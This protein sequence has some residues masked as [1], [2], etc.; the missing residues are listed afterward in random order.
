MKKMGVSLII[1]AMIFV[2][3]GCNKEKIEMTDLNKAEIESF[4]INNKPISSPLELYSITELQSFFGNQWGIQLEDIN[5]RFAIEYLRKVQVDSNFD[6]YYVAYPVSEGGK[7]LLFLTYSIDFETDKIKLRSSDY[8]YVNDLSD[9]KEFDEVDG[10]CT[11][12]DIKSLAPCTLLVS[13]RSSSTDSYSL[14]MDGNV[15][16][17]TYGRTDGKVISHKVISVD[18]SISP[19]KSIIP[20][21]LSP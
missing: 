12:D 14:L 6:S 17:C 5:D 20:E 3:C 7:F 11:Y 18:D 9:E 21:D 13:T 16:E 2:I 10:N 1:F 4:V 15:M 8:I 19:F